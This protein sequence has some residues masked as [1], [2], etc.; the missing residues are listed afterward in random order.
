MNQNK[1]QKTVGSEWYLAGGVRVRII[2]AFPQQKIHRKYSDTYYIVETLE[3]YTNKDKSRHYTKGQKNRINGRNLWPQSQLQVQ[4][5]K[6]QKSDSDYGYSGGSNSP[7]FPGEMP[8][9][10]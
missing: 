5:R 8:T 1:L 9:L 7:T 4:L 2:E 6:N 10:W 3:D